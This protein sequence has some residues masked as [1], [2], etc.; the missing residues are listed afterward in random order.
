MLRFYL[1]KFYAYSPKNCAKI[2]FYNLKFY[3][4]NTFL[5]AAYSIYVIKFILQ[6]LCY[7]IYNIN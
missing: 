6:N 1:D 7:K 3:V 5:Y 2:L 4:I